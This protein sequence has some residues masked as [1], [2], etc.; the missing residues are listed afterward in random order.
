[1]GHKDEPYIPKKKIRRV[2]KPSNEPCVYSILFFDKKFFFTE[3]IHFYFY[4]IDL[5]TLFNRETYKNFEGFDRGQESVYVGW[6]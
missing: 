4:D 5:L 1:M 6:V 3:I 2:V